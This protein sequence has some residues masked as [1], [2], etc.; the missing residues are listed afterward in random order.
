MADTYVDEKDALDWQTRF[1]IIMGI[2]RGL[3]YLHEDSPVRI[4]HRDIKATNILLDNNLKP[5]IADFGLARLFEYDM[6]H[7][8]TRV[9]GTLGY[10]SPEYARS[11]KLTEK[12]DIYSFGMVMLEIVSSKRVVDDEF[13]GDEDNLL[14]YAWALYEKEQL[15]Q[16]VDKRLRKTPDSLGTDD[17]VSLQVNVQE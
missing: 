7:V 1:D 3:R 2:A 5:K 12:A 8:T 6:T 17:D 10:L 9:A 14:D 4:V 16:I 11:G 15:L 13:D